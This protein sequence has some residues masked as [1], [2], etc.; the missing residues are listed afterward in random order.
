DSEPGKGTNFHVYLPVTEQTATDT[1]SAT[2]LP[3]PTGSGERILF[4]DDEEQICSMT[5]LLLGRNGYLV[6]SFND[7]KD[8]LHA[9]A[10][11][12]DRFDLVITDMTMPHLNGAELAHQLLAIMPSL[13]I[14][15]CT[16]QSELIDRE[17]AMAMGIQDYLIKPIPKDTLLGTLQ[18]VL[19]LRQKHL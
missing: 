17:K 19:S 8:A 14:I 10:Q 16:G 1:P 6:T 15:L 7:P 12:P 3:A 18:R 11:Q 5:R 9:F 4:V 13:P 2:P